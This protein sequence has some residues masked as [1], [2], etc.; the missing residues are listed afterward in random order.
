MNKF[1]FDEPIDRHGTLSY[2]WDTI[3]DKE[4]LPLWVADMDFMAAPA[5]CAAVSRCARHGIFGYATTNE[6]YY[7]AI[8]SFNRRHYGV[9]LER[10]WIM[11]VPGIV[12]ALTAVLQALT[13]PGDEVILQ[14]P[15]YN[16]FFSCIA[17]SGLTAKENRLIYKDGRFFLDF[18]DLEEKASSP[19]AR[20][21]LV[22]NPHNPSGRLWKEEELKRIASIARKYNLTVI[23]DEIHCDIRPNG[24][25]FYAFSSI[26][27]S[28]KD[29]LITLAAPSKT[30]NI[31][32]LK[33]AH[34]I[35]ANR[36]FRYRIDRQININEICDVNVFGIA[37]TIAAYTEC[38]DWLYELNDY[39]QENYRLLISF[40]EENYPDIKVADLESTYLAWIDCACLKLDGVQIRNRLLKEGKL[41][42]NDGQMYHSA[43]ESFI[44][45]NLA[46][47]KATLAEALRRFRKVFPPN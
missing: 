44:R 34:V 22:C 21:L 14:T 5:I 36:D 31:A 6:D 7:N 46:C 28:L 37:A 23:S 2:K 15:A 40:F 27:E 33:S 41:F 1:N 12:P 16:C 26:D 4:V 8:I 19:K 3:S 43:Q 30:F 45:I 11:P 29:R 25:R 38:D 17:N 20:V 42:V 13:Q 35:C 10:D 18:T 32:G 39:I 24:S 9:Q 47:T